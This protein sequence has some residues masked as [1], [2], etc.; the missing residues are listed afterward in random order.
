MTT[1]RAANPSASRRILH[2]A[3]WVTAATLLVKLSATGKELLVAAFFTRSAVVDAFLV[4]LLIPNLLVNLFAESMNQ[5]LV[6]ALIRTRAA[7]GE[8]AA[9]RLLSTALLFSFLLLVAL[10]AL[11]ALAAPCFFPILFH[12]PPATLALAVHL[13]RALLLFTLFGA[14]ASNGTAVLN[15]SERFAAPAF[16]PV[17]VPLSIL[18]ALLLLPRRVGIWSLVYGNLFGAFLWALVVGALVLRSG[19]RFLRPILRVTPELR[20]LSAQY[21]NIF[22]SSVVSS[23]GL[24]VD[25]LMASWLAVGSVAALNWASRFSAVLMTILGG[26]IGTAITPYLAQA[27]AAR[28][29]TG[30]R[31]ILRHYTALAAAVT[32]PL[33]AILIL[34]SRPII[35]LAFQHGSFRAADTHVVA[36]IQS[37]FALQIPFFVVSRVF[38]RFLLVLQRSSLVLACGTINLV[39]DI[40]FNLAFMHFWGVVGIALATSLWMVCTFLFLAFWARHLLRQSAASEA[41]N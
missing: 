18:A 27:V 7:S 24:L 35:A 6:P 19:Q 30:C 40:V 26:A 39:L 5:A 15:A 17:L 16:A 33:A 12:F 1:A 10:A 11:L 21:A 31:R 4:A 9:S 8:Q 28:D 14:L 25:V 36:S 38:Y 13:F 41:A 29:W 20:Q 22:L 3:S 34:A 32:L 23:G 2:A 37:A